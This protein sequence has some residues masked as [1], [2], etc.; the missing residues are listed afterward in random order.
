MI[1]HMIVINCNWYTHAQYSS[2]KWQWCLR[3]ENCSTEANKKLKVILKLLPYYT[4]D[5]TIW[6]RHIVIFLFFL[7]YHSIS[8]AFKAKCDLNFLLRSPTTD[9]NFLFFCSNS[10][11]EAFLDISNDDAM[12]YNILCVCVCVRNPNIFL[13]GK[14]RRT[15]KREREDY[16]LAGAI[17]NITKFI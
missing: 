1:T 9:A 14:R 12:L 17:A 6:K 2:D 11:K 8:K 5:K 4:H 13:Y 7:H 10:K 3:F 16:F 15:R